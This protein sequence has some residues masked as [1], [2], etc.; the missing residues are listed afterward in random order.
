M[1][2][3]LSDSTLMELNTIRVWFQIRTLS[4]ALKSEKVARTIGTTFGTIMMVDS[5]LV[6]LSL[7][8]HMQVEMV[9]SNVIWWVHRF[10]GV[11]D[12]YSS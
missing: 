11:A 10:I 3:G 4:L 9:V 12:Q 2:D 8:V 5:D 6:P 7:V 1:I